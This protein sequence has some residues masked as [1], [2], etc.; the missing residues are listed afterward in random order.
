MDKVQA[1]N[2]FW[3]SFGIPAFDENTVPEKVPDQNGNMVPL[4]PPYITYNVVLD[5]MGSAVAANAE[6]WYRS[7]S[8]AD[9]T[10]KE[11]AIAEYITRG[12]RMVNYDGGAFWIQKARP[13]AQRLSESNDGLVRRVILNVT[14]EF[15]D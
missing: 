5:S 6:L 2:N 13:W 8:W 9:V 12:G 10:R 14:I 3:N 1:I 11:Q 15:L 4:T 7:S